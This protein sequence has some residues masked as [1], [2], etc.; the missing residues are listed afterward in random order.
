MCGIA[1]I[2]RW[3]GATPERDVIQRMTARLAH[4]GPDGEGLHISANGAALG[5]RRLSIID[6]SER[7]AQPMSNARGDVWLAFNGEIYN[8]RELRRQL[9]HEGARFRTD[10]DSET[11]LQL[12]EAYGDDA[13]G[14]L[15]ELRGMFA[16]AIWDER[17]QR[18]I[19]ARDRLGIKPLIFYAGKDFIAFASEMDALLECPDVP[20]KLDWTSVF[21]YL[22]LLTVPSPHT[23]FQDVEH[24]KP[25]A[26][27][28]AE[29]SKTRAFSYWKLEENMTPVITD[30]RAADE[31]LEA[32]LAE[33]VRL[34]LVADVEVGAFLSGGV[35]SGL[36]TA[37]ATE[38]GAEGLQ[39]FSATFPDEEVDEGPWAAEAA[40]RLGANHTEFAVK[41][42][43][44]NGIENIARYFD[45]PMAITSAV[46]L[47]HLSRM[48]RERVKVV[49]TGDGG[50]EIFG[51]Y[52]RH[53]AYPA[54]A[55][56]ASWMPEGMRPV[57]GRV[58]VSV[59][60]AWARRRSS[61]LQKAHGLAGQLARDETSLYVP[62]LYYWQPEAAL[63]LLS[64]EFRREVDTERYKTRVRRLFARC[65]A[66]DRVTRMLFV[67][68]HTSLVDEMLTKVDRMTM[69]HGLEA[70][71]PLLDH[72]VVELAMR[73]AGPLKRQ[74]GQGKL[75][76]RRLVAPRL[77]QATAQRGKYGFNSPL[78]D[79][80]RDDLATRLK[81]AELWPQAKQSG[82]FIPKDLDAARERFHKGAGVS[83]MNLFTLF[84]FGLWAER[85]N[86]KV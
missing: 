12:Y 21:D 34:H 86:V 20:R 31:E 64:P 66:S 19:L 5:H 11:I 17:R 22:T 68:L 42:G 37:M 84:T 57:V 44:L 47:Y 81:F 23:I 54:P 80:L 28:V 32:E 2:Y 46:S 45:Q 4:R 6:L 73:I 43:F 69:A 67:D 79:W 63:S 83:A 24:L 39:T 62:R 14:F 82:A 33:A 36:V 50:D 61:A 70:R 60:P 38:Q 48:A 30:A 52:D 10:S 8:Y 72:K 51:G 71:V 26:V 55:R 58:G 29:R 59:L 78:E 15:N 13:R 25:G 18:L 35:D 40:R 9:E 7:A 16:F 77:G 76:L 65:P 75:P 53:R 1:G 41:D 56:A 49:L 27:I 74:G 3:D 85:N